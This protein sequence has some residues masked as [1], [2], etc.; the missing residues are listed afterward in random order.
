M[1]YNPKSEFLQEMLTRGFLQD[2]TDLQGL[3]E[4]LL[5]GCMPAYIG[6]DATA[7]SLH[8]GSLIQIMMLRWLQKTGHKPMPL[9]GGGTTKIGDP[10]GKDESRQLITTDT[11]NTNISGI[12][13]VFEKYLTFGVNRTDAKIINNSE[14]LDKLNYI[15]F[16]RDIGKHFTINRMISMESVKLRLDREQPLTFLEFNYMLL[17]AY[18]F[19]ELNNRYEVALQMGGSDQWGNIVN[20]IDLTRRL[21][22]NSVFGLTTPLLTKAD[23]SKMGKSANGAIWLNSDKLSPY[24]F[25]QYWRNTLDADVGKFLKLFTE[26]PVIECE[27]LGALE[28]QNINE[29]KIILANEVT[30]LCHGSQAAINSANTAH[31]VFSEDGSDENLPTLE[32]HNSEIID[33]LSFTQALLKTGLVSSGKEAKRIIA[34]G[35]AR[36]N[37]QIITDAGYMLERSEL[38]NILKITASKK[39]H[40]LIKIIQ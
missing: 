1:T 33:G 18:D 31:K 35:G 22:K 14:W 19:M 9:M 29:A 25:W 20:G 10:S 28:G 36:L 5:E 7:D 15:E 26:L 4:K 38:N 13:K 30:K 3:D 8:I 24:E 2:C 23:G 21:N 27:R 11:I 37:D 6:F 32:I 40:A 16:L 12:Q 39:K 34:G 17:Q